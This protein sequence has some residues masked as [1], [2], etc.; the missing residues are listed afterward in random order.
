MNSEIRVVVAV[1]VLDDD[2]V[3]DL[4]TDT[5]AVVVTCFD[6]A[7]DVPITIL[8]KDAASVVAIEVF[9]IRTIPVERNV[10]DQYVCCMFTGQ[11]RKQRRAG[12]LAAGPEIF[13]KSVVQLEAIAIASH[14]SSLDDRRAVVVRIRRL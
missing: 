1:T 6:I 3:T 5:V 10:L 12:W 7:E 2:I 13:A 11:Q 14:Q 8:Q 4:E 9:A